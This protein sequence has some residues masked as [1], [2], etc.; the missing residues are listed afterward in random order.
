MDVNSSFTASSYSYT[1]G[2]PM[3]EQM[4]GS[5][6][7]IIAGAAILLLGYIANLLRLTVNRMQLY[8]RVIFGETDL[9][10]PGLIEKLC[11]HEKRLDKYRDAYLLS[12]RELTKAGVLLCD[13]DIKD[14]VKEMRNEN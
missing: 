6:W 7:D 2:D 9:K 1:I 10:Q 11:L 14:M 3:I 12:I 5:F 8:D 13:G 4:V